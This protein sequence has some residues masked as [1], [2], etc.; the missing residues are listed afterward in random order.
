MLFVASSVVEALTS[1]EDDEG[2]AE[3]PVCWARASPTGNA[4]SARMK[5]D[6]RET[7]MICY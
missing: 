6:E 1:W 4:Q 7:L 5:S 2:V 3:V